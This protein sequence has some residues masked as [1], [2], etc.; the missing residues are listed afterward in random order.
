MAGL[1]DRT[2]QPTPQRLK[3]AREEGRFAVSREMSAA[4]QF[5]AAAL[6]FNWFSSSSL[7]QVVNWLRG[8]L[9]SALDSSVPPSLQIQFR[10]F[11]AVSLVVP[12]LLIVSFAPLLFG[13]MLQ[14]Q[15]GI[16]ASQLRPQYS[17]LL[18]LQKL[19]SLPSQNGSSVAQAFLLSALTAV[20]IKL[21]LWDRRDE[22]AAIAFLDLPRGLAGVCDLLGG[23]LS[24]LAL[25]VMSW[26]LIDYVISK[27]RFMKQLRMTKQEIREE[28]RQNE[29]SPEVKS[30]IRRLRRDLLRRRMM[31][32]VPKASVVVTNPTHFAVALRYDM[33][34]MT[35]PQVVAKG[36][37]Y[38][39]LRIREKALQHLVPVVENK[40][41]AQALYRDVAVG[42]EIPPQLYR[43][44]AEILAYVRKMSSHGGL[45][46]K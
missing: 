1:G 28:W 2:E 26:G 37:N 43:A 21:E 22:V 4:L 20:M 8:A 32:E 36:K 46:S 11:E 45:S 41:L 6:A 40:P 29:G 18:N 12:A 27:R 19:T 9:I 17:R 5:S 30:R 25:A 31:S 13:Q 44:A 7:T 35:A 3:K 14:T 39:A 38:L 23:I 33:A 34:T 16:A 42:Q 15:G 10:L 24:K